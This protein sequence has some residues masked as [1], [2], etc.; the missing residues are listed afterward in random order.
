MNVRGTHLR[1]LLST[2]RAIIQRDDCT[3]E[4]IQRVRTG[5]L[6]FQSKNDLLLFTSNVCYWSLK[7]H[8][9][10]SRVLFTC[11]F[12][13]NSSVLGIH[14]IPQNT[15]FFHKAVTCIEVR[16]TNWYICIFL[17]LKNRIT[18][19]HI[20]LP[21]LPRWRTKC[22]KCQ[23]LASRLEAS[24]FSTLAGSHHSAEQQHPE[25]DFLALLWRLP[26]SSASPPP[27][28]L[29]FPGRPPLSHPLMPRAPSGRDWQHL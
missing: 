25:Q 11:N 7:M 22:I 24:Q 14:Y 23:D 26:Q 3:C 9:F 27:S 17:H 13:F 21:H 2:S 6:G 10:K 8:V 4:E 5:W 16:I 15:L 1:A 12:K 18:I 28:P 19:V 29:L 20:M